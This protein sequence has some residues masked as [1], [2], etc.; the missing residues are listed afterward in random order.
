MNTDLFISFLLLAVIFIVIPG[1][2]VWLIVGTSVAKG[3]R[4]G[5]ETVLGTSIA[6]SIQLLIAVIYGRHGKFLN[7]GILLSLS[8]ALAVSR[9]AE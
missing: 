2:N 1:P 4:Q 6:M 9:Q 8:T 5:F 3:R 7:G